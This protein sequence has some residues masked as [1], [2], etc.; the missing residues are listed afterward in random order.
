MK[1]C[2]NS[3]VLYLNLLLREWYTTVSVYR[4]AI[5]NEELSIFWNKNALAYYLKKNMFIMEPLH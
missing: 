3:E 5:E 4:T 1:H 2:E